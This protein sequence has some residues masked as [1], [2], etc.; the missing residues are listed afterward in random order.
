MDRCRDYLGFAVRYFGLSYLLLWPLSTPGH[1]E[2][3]GAAVVCGGALDVLCR[4]PHP[5]HFG[6]GLHWAGAVC[7]LFASADPAIRVLVRARLRRRDPGSS[8]VAGAVS[9]PPRRMRRRP[10]PPPRRLIRPRSHF[11]LRGVPR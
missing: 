11:G 1:G 6:T 9:P 4:L 2:L 10:W 5:L 8:D 7:A 3:F